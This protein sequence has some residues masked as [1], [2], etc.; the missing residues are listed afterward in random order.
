MQQNA[1]FRNI[2]KE[3][4]KNDAAISLATK[5]LQSSCLELAFE[6]FVSFVTKTSWHDTR[7]RGILF[8]FE[9][10]RLEGGKSASTDD[11]VLAF[12]SGELKE[13]SESSNRRARHRLAVGT[14]TINGRPASGEITAREILIRLSDAISYAV[15]ESQ[16]TAEKIIRPNETVCKAD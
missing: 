14:L 4:C 15:K 13:V 3:K 1:L 7:R 16:I 2:E 10:E 11:Q 8:L 12:A 9:E 6:Q 5:T